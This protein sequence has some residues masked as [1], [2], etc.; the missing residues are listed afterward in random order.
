MIVRGAQ[1]DD[2]G[3]ILELM[4]PH[5][6]AE[7]LLPRD[8]SEVRRRLHEFVLLEEPAGARP[9]GIAALHHYGAGLAEVRSLTVAEEHA[10]KGH[11][12]R[13]VCALIERARQENLGRVIALTRTPE[14]FERI[15]FARTAIE[16]LP[17]KVSRDCRFCP[18]R[19]R[20][21]EVAMVLEL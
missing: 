19:D 9:I 6:A 14:F 4:A 16:A 21:D 3:R 13:L 17:E 5:V 7:A 11:G 15:G 12:R 8:E 20:C 1:P 18:R 2:V 10:G